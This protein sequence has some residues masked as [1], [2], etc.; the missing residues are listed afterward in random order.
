MVIYTQ[1]GD[2]GRRLERLLNK[3]NPIEG[4]RG[5][6][7]SAC[8]QVR[9]VMESGRGRK[10]GRLVRLHAV[11]RTAIA[12]D[13]AVHQ[14]LKNLV[15]PRLFGVLNCEMSISDWR[16]LGMSGGVA[17]GELVP[18]V[19]EKG[20]ISG[21]RPGLSAETPTRRWQM[22]ARLWGASAQVLRPVQTRTSYGRPD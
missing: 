14:C 19:P 5:R 3:N 4:Q 11:R 15:R 20:T 10:G 21:T 22:I 16:G 18:A 7:R 2:E 12:S 9:Y 13:E 1:G 17:S 8:H 6:K